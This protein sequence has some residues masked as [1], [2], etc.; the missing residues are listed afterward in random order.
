[1]KNMR[2]WFGIV[3]SV[4]WLIA[5]L[6]LLYVKRADLAGLTINAWG[7]FFAGFAA[8][9]AF[10]WLVLGYLQQGEELK[11]ST[12]ALNVQA[13]ELKNS[14]EQQQKLVEAA[15]AQVK[16]EQEALKLDMI[17]RRER[18]QP[19]FTFSLGTT[20]H[21]GGNISQIVVVDNAG[22]SASDVKII[23]SINEENEK[24]VFRAPTFM[25]RT[26][27]DFR[28]DLP[29]ELLEM[30]SLDGGILTVSY[31]DADHHEGS[32]VYNV[33]GGKNHRMGFHRVR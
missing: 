21:I 26:A 22:N 11:L 8:P 5:S 7:D 12:K 29:A 23:F 2:F 15:W 20:N 1:M 27:T 28:I 3:L 18:A 10:L 14:V 4:A 13:E 24:E 30:L 31:I 25:E 9:L 6:A 17:H 33:S 16:N 19:L 32:A